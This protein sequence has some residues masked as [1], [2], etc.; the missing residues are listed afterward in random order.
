MPFGINDPKEKRVSFTADRTLY[1]NADQ[2]K[3]VEEGDSAAA[4]LLVREGSQI[5]TALA[6]RY[7]LKSSAKAEDKAVAAPEADKA[8]EPEEAEQET[9]DGD[10]LACP[11]D[12][13]DFVAKSAGGLTRHV[14]A[15]HEDQE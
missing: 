14:N 7:G 13:C 2:S 15:Q 11:V 1:L 12:G 5:D 10:E 8:D 3:V 6:E 9:E 4:F